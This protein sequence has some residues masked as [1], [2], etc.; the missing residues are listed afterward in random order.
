MDSNSIKQMLQMEATRRGVGGA[1]SSAGV[2]ASQ[3]NSPM[4][5]NPMMQ[6]GTR[7]QGSPALPESMYQGATQMMNGAKPASAKHIENALIKRM[8]MYPPQ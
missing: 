6:N 5:S 3:A 7:Q 2:G 8:M 1:P 4:P